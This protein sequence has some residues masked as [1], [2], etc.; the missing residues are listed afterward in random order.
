MSDTVWCDCGDAIGTGGQCAT[1]RTIDAQD[2]N[3]WRYPSRGE[4]PGKEMS[5]LKIN[6]TSRGFDIIEFTDRNGVDCTI[7]KS[8]LATEDAIWFGCQDPNPRY[9]SAK[10]WTPLELPDYTIINTRMHLTRKQVRRLLPIL[11]RFAKTGEIV[12]APELEEK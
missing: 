5:K 2:P 7:Q 10:G 8:S 4:L 3:P 6:L 11:K 1:C 9:F 12:A